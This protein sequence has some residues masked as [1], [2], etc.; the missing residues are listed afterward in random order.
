MSFCKKLAS[1]WIASQ[2]YNDKQ[3][4]HPSAHHPLP[5]TPCPLQ[6]RGIGGELRGNFVCHF[7]L[8]ENL[9]SLG[10]T[11]DKFLYNTGNQYFIKMNPAMDLRSV[12]A[13]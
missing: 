8:F 13:L 12:N 11:N 3:K 7:R 9:F 4:V 2:T 6:R 5:T 1:F 10:A